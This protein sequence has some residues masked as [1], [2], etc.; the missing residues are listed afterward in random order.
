MVT[1]GITLAQINNDVLNISIDRK[2]NED[3]RNLNLTWNTIKYENN[4]I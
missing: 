4:I 2:S 1:E 3:N